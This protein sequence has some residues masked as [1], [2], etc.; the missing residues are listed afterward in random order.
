MLDFAARPE[1]G[2]VGA[3]L[4]YPDG[5]LQHGGVVLGLDGFA[6]HAQRLLDADDP[7]YLGELAWPREVSAVTGACLALEARKF[8]EV[9][10]FDEAR[11]P[12]EYN[13]IDLCLRLAERGYVCVFEPR[14]RL[15]HRESASRGAN[16]WLDSRYASEHNYFRE[17]WARRL[18][19]D[20][21][22]H[23]ALSLDALEIA[24]G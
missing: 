13:D 5:R 11:L 16:T 21:Y 6:G 15:M 18:R 17:R 12:I 19:D 8:R 3:K 22:F 10:G 20:P 7:G 1:V 4:T 24:L 23:P 14:A 9:G 2:A